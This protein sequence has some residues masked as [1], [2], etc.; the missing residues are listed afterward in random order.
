MKGDMAVRSI[1]T[2][3]S[4]WMARRPPR[5][6]SRV[7]GSTA[8]LRRPAPRCWAMRFTPVAS[9]LAEDGVAVQ[10]PEL[11][12]GMPRWRTHTRPTNPGASMLD[13]LE[14]H[15]KSLDDYT[16][17]RWH[18]NHKVRLAMRKGTLLQNTASREG[19]VSARCYRSGAFGFASRPGD[20]D[21]AIASALADA[22]A[23]AALYE[24]VAGVHPA[25]LPQTAPGIGQYD[26]RS[27]QKPL[28]AIERTDLLRGLNDAI[29]TKYPGLL[30]TDLVLMSLAI[31]K[32][33]VTSEGAA[34]Y[35]YVPRTV[36]YIQLSLQANDGPV[37]LYDVLG[38]LG[39]LQD[40]AFEPAR[41]LERVDALYAELRD[42]AEGT[43][44]EAGAHDVVLDSR[45]A[46]IL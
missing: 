28:S 3:I 26:Y 2:S 14:R 31:E 41:L 10:P 13:R 33:L 8:L 42:K 32:A 17:L 12:D 37:E 16:E 25:P 29:A 30:N 9:R 1:S 24:R 6:I 22:R 45:V 18:A 11:L 40:H 19:G 44:C 4:D 38:G 15:A 5:M 34:T 36:L 21:A 23:N 7:T 39:D 35:S 20:G 43:H 46:G 27:R